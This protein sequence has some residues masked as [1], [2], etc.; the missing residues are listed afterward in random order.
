MEWGGSADV[1]V[2]GAGVLGCSVAHAFASGGRSVVVVDALSGPGQ[3][4]TSA[5]SAIIRFNYST[6]AGVA[7]AWESHFWWERWEEFLGGRDDDGGLASYTRTGGVCL[8]APVHDSDHVLALFDQVGVPYERW[9]AATLRARLPML[10]AARF[11]PP[12]PVD[13]EDFF[14]DPDGEVGGYWTPDS[15]FVDDPGYAAHN[16]ATAAK[17]LGAQF[18]F[19]AE[20]GAVRTAGGRVAGVELGDG[21]RIDAPVVVNVAGPASGRV[22]ALAGVGEEFAVQTRP[23]RAEVH[24]VPAPPG[25]RGEVDRAGRT[26]P[27]PL[28]ADLD[29][30][31]YFRGTPGG[32]VLVGGAEPACDPLHWLEDPD[33]FDRHVTAEQ[34]QAQVYRVARR[35]PDLTVPNTPHGLAAAYD[36]SDDWIPIYDRTSLE[37]FH[38]AIG[39]SGNQ[40]KNAPLVGTYLRALVEAG[41]AGHDHDA[42]PVHLTLP[43]SGVEVDLGTFSRLRPVTP[44]SSFSVMG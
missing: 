36:V 8:D 6:H 9:D 20:V 15:G 25:Y 29:L 17:R 26:T 10:D 42:D 39:T 23:L 40:F 22:N 32:E 14:K 33:D 3:G 28:V 19:R 41:E 24:T 1:V 31:T 27:G 34:Y 5:S 4:S 13:S 43:H 11:Y 21:E 30:G 35:L 44:G 37:G 7:T 2:V 18:R 12:A 38:V 16:L